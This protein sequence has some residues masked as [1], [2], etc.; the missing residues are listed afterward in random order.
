MPKQSNLQNIKMYKRYAAKLSIIQNKSNKT[1]KIHQLHLHKQVHDK[2]LD[3][4]LKFIQKN[5]NV[6]K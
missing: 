2:I 4:H 3:Y 5:N 6:Q 1:Q